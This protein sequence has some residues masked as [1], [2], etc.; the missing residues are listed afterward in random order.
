MSQ[1]LTELYNMMMQADAMAQGGDKQAKLDAE[2]MFAEIQRIEG[3]REQ[4][5]QEEGRQA[6]AAVSIAPEVL[7]QA[8]ITA[9]KPLIGGAVPV[10]PSPVAYI[11]LPIDI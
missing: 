7:S 11:R 9:A 10:A 1:D 8:A 6:Q 5:Q 3:E 2:D 4:K